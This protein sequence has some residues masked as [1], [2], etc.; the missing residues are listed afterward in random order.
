MANI[1]LFGGAG[2][3]LLAEG[4]LK[5]ALRLVRLRG[6]AA[7][8][9]PV[10]VRRNIAALLRNLALHEAPA[11]VLVRDGGIRAVIELI[12]D[13]KPATASSAVDPGSAEAAAA[14]TAAAPDPTASVTVL[15]DA[16]ARLLSFAHD[17]FCW[18]MLL[19][20]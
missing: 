1:A 7:V 18:S 4:A 16:D 17:L 2:T 19:P 8:L 9:L 12:C 5:L 11:R 20:S 13:V 6:V 10:A 3:A 14:A 15:A